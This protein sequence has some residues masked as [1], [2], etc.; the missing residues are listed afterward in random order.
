M[1]STRKSPILIALVS[2]VALTASL[3]GCSASG[4]APDAIAGTTWGDPTAENTPSL[5]FEDDGTVF[6]TDGCNRLNGSWTEEGDTVEFGALAST[7]MFCEGVDTWLGDSAT[8]VR[9]DKTL[10]LSDESGSEIGK[11]ELSETAK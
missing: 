10:I 6:G 7:M 2:A 9:Q 3:A 4:D 1:T 11:L 8:A 5:T